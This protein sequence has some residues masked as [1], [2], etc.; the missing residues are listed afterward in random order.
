M[1]LWH[2]PGWPL[3]RGIFF[4][5]SLASK[6]YGQIAQYFDMLRKI[7]QYFIN[8]FEILVLRAKIWLFGGNR[9]EK[10]LPFPRIKKNALAF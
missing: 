8:F 9:D 5:N 4:Q 3:I 10:Y 1:E 2:V 7:G 6:N